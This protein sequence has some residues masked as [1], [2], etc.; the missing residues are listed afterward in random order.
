[1][2]FYVYLKDIFSYNLYLQYVFLSSQMFPL[3]LQHICIHIRIHICSFLCRCK[4]GFIVTV[5]LLM[6]SLYSRF[7]WKRKS[8]YYNLHTPT[9]LIKSSIGRIYCTLFYAYTFVPYKIKIANNNKHICTQIYKSQL[10]QSVLSQR[11]PQIP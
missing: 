5:S 10:T 11:F 8:F 1:M 3:T 7:L 9:A 6:K 2:Y 4:N